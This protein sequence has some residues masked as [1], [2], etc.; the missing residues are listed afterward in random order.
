[1]N[2]TDP[3][4]KEIGKIIAKLRKEH[5][6]SQKDL[7]DKIGISFQSVSKWEHG[8]VISFENLYALSRLFDVSIDYL[9]G[10]SK[11]KTMDQDLIGRMT[12]LSPEAV[13]RLC[14]YKTSWD[15]GA[16]YETIFQM[17]DKFNS[18]DLINSLIESD[19]F[20]S[21]MMCFIRMCDAQL[22]MKLA[23]DFVKLVR[24]TAPPYYASV[25]MEYPEEMDPDGNITIGSRE[26]EQFRTIQNQSDTYD[27]QMFKLQTVMAEHMNEVVK[28]KL[29]TNEMIS[30]LS[31]Q[32]HQSK[33]ALRNNAR[34]DAAGMWKY[35][36]LPFT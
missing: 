21:I 13:R 12:G 2:I 33:S 32:A 24:V 19:Q 8:E 35:T 5:N 36:E 11:Y 18:L 14:S 30:E 31:K 4:Y 27:S 23:E 22:Q 34:E 7:A 15:R 10:R 26:V 16:K 6:W 9:L 1:M 25:E 28:K 3:N 20:D 29:V 17:T